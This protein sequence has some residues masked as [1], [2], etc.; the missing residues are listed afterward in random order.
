MPPVKLVWSH[1]KKGLLFNIL[2]LYMNFCSLKGTIGRFYFFSSW[3]C[4]ISSTTYGW[5]SWYDTLHSFELDW[6]AFNCLFN[7][8]VVYSLFSDLLHPLKQSDFFFF[9]DNIIE[10][11]YFSCSCWTCLSTGKCLSKT[12][13]SHG[14]ILYRASII[15]GSSF[16]ERTKVNPHLQMFSLII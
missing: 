9:K 4:C 8:L 15:Q 3:A 1:L 6:L 5:F 11:I 10:F 14:V 7:D 16:S 2:C 13:S 12:I